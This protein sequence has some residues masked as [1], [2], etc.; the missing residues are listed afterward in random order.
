MA[1][2][3]KTISPYCSP[4]PLRNEEA[5]V[6]VLCSEQEGTPST[7]EQL[8]PPSYP[9]SSPQWLI[10]CLA[11]FI[12]NTQGHPLSSLFEMGSQMQ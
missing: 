11:P 7:R 3:P 12:L 10:Y 8:G 5:R 2:P 4:S 6:E 9:S 1:S